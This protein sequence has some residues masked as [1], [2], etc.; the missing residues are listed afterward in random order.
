MSHD[1]S[2]QSSGNG[3]LA[4][5]AAVTLESVVISEGPVARGLR[6]GKPVCLFASGDRRRSVPLLP[7]HETSLAAVSDW[8]KPGGFSFP[9]SL[10]LTSAMMTNTLKR[11][12]FAF[13][14]SA[15]RYVGAD[16]G[17]A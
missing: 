16:S 11:R 3:R 5:N 1:N 2:L 6:F 8:I 4:V 10:P 15:H 13:E 14:E 12:A 17:V 7:G 9:N